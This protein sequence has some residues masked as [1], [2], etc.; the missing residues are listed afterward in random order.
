VTDGPHI[1][2]YSDLLW[3]S[4]RAVREIGDSGTNEEIVERV[5]ATE[6]FTDEQLGVPSNDGRRGMIEYRLAWARSYLKG[7]GLLDKV[8]NALTAAVQPFLHSER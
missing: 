5:I 8:W 1:P 6:G 4:L 2:A 7:M 3:S